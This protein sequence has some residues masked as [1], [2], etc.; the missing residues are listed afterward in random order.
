MALGQK[1][2]KQKTKNKKQKTKNKK[3]KTNLQNEDIGNISLSP[4]TPPPP[5]LPLLLPLPPPPHHDTL[6]SVYVKIQELILPFH[7]GIAGPNS[8]CQPCNMITTT[9]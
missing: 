1:Q 8:C 7:S 4:S 2:K 9:F 5:P 6:Q 3:Q